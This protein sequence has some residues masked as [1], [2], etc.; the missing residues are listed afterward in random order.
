MLFAYKSPVRAN[1][2]SAFKRFLYKI[3]NLLNKI[4]IL[5]SLFFI[6]AYTQN[7]HAQTK[8]WNNWYFGFKAGLDFNTEPPTVLTNGQTQTYTGNA[9]ISDENGNLLFYSDGYKVWDKNHN[10]MPN[11]A[12]LEGA[13]GVMQNILIIPYPEQLQLYYLFVIKV[14]YD[15]NN[16]PHYNLL[17]SIID[18]NLNNG[19]G[20][21]DINNKDILLAND[22]INL[23]AAA[24]PDGTGYWMAV[25]TADKKIYVFSIN[26][27]GINT[28]PIINPLS[29]PLKSLYGEMRFS[30]N[31]KK[32]AI[33]SYK[34]NGVSERD[35]SLLQIYDFNS[36][37][38]TISF[39]KQYLFSDANNIN[40]NEKIIS[41]I[42]FSPDNSKIYANY[43]QNVGSD[44]IQFDLNYATL[45]PDTVYISGQSE[46][47]GGMRLAPNGKIYI[48][49]EGTNTLNCIENPDNPASTCGFVLNAI[50][51]QTG[52]GE[53][54][55][56]NTIIYPTFDFIYTNNCQ[57]ETTIFTITNTQNIQSTL[58][59]FGDNQTSTQLEPSHT[60]LNPGTYTVTL[61]VT[62]NDNSTKTISK[63]ITVY[64]QP[65]Q[66][67]ILHH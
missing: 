13:F 28:T 29:N 39:D 4:I 18:M 23:T 58:W 25:S 55:L 65:V 40:T 50:N 1:I 45:E 14:I 37:N 9:T 56:P 3:M 33:T 27:V 59:N 63:E 16:K 38:G 15:S 47:F 67:I 46:P 51:L 54:S 60:Y 32:F 48:I 12:N 20:D 7:I 52:K 10:V 21:I 53:F 31:G 22:V 49:N 42:E 64:N 11:G 5:S 8:I 30:N 6:F 41:T 19:N 35:S 26:S 24:K 61:T 62:Y 44:L 34:I 17:Y 66:N 36:S 2:I 43:Y 57:F